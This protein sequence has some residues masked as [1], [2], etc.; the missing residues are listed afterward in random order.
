MKHFALL[1]ILLFGMSCADPQAPPPNPF[2]G[3]EPTGDTLLI[4]NQ[5]LSLNSIEGLHAAVFLPTCANSGC[6][7]GNFEPDFRSINSTYNTLVYHPV[8]KNNPAGD[9]QYRVKPGDATA[10]VLWERLNRDIDGQ[11]GRMPL[12]IDPDSDW[13]E[14]KETYLEHIQSWI[15]SG[16]KDMFGN[17]PQQGNILPSSRGMVAFA[18]GAGTILDRQSG[19][20]PVVV[21]SGTS[22][23][24]LWFSFEDD[25]TESA[26]LLYNQLKVSLSANAFDG[27]N[28]Q[29]LEIETPITEVGLF[30][31]PE[32][33]S[34]KIS[35]SVT[36]YSSGDQVFVRTYV[37]EPA[38]STLV[39]IP[40]DESAL[41]M[42]QYFS[43]LMM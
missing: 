4:P 12:G 3:N 42:K 30:G 13:P 24:I 21:P 19:S 7:D 26:Q 32:F 29:A 28:E 8:I 10:S 15:N 37:K 33:F 38:Q 39:E 2:E 6:H 18:D 14:K 27:S 11:S 34:H 35:L 40:S 16:A 9:F 23:L 43:F 17:L 25:E 1:S 36:S 20:G 22:Q 5:S 41:Y 31:S